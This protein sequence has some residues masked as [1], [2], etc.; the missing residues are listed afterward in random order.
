[1]SNDFAMFAGDN[2][3]IK[4]T[5]RNA[6]DAIVNITGATIDWKAATVPF[7]TPILEKAGQIIDGPAGRFDVSL[8]P[9]DTALLMGNLFHW[10]VITEAGN[11]VSTMY[12]GVIAISPA[13]DLVTA[14]M[15]IARFPEFA[16]VPLAT[17]QMIIAEAVARVGPTWV[18]QDRTPA[19]LYLVAHLIASQGAGGSSA[20]GGGVAV[21]GAL[22][23]RKVGDVEVEF[24][25]QGQVGSGA[26]DDYKT[27]SYGRQFLRYMRLSFPAVAVV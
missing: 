18:T 20:G 25:G 13:S 7:S 2:R 11:K 15:V 16:N 5:V 1:M 8:L 14:E 17:I 21:T 22:K 9:V 10:A 27:T 4:I 26:L 23:R 6:Q 19:V 3:T 12:L 24:A